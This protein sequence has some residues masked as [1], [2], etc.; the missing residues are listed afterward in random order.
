MLGKMDMLLLNGQ[1]KLMRFLADLEK[2]E[3]GASDMVAIMVVIVIIIGVA[4]A[5][6][7]GLE[8]AIEAVFSK[9]TD[10]IGTGA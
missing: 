6:K 4:V 9:L 8:K 3:K 10:F 7:D 2:E 5:F 1:A